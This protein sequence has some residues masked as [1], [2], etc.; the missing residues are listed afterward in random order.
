MDGCLRDEIA[1][2]SITAYKLKNCD[3][4]FRNVGDWW[5]PVG[6]Q[7]CSRV[8]L[9]TQESQQFMVQVTCCHFTDQGNAVQPRG[10][11]QDTGETRRERNKL[12]GP[13]YAHGVIKPVLN[14]ERDDRKK[15][16]VKMRNIQRLKNIKRRTSIM[17]WYDRV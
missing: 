1:L 10:R 12:L 13:G 6:L 16:N 14:T 3:K 9:A 2:G 8:I 15:E 11:R 4:Q 5:S 7:L 17:T